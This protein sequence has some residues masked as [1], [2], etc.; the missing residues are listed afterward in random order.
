MQQVAL[1]HRASLRARRC[2][3]GSR[4]TAKTAWLRLN[5]YARSM[6]NE[7]RLLPKR[8]RQR[9]IASVVGRKRI[10]T[11]HELLAALAA[12]GCRVTQATVSRD[13]RDLGL[14]KTHDLLG[15]PRYVLPRNG[16]RADP[17]ENLAGVLTQFGRGAVAA[18]NIVV[19]RS[20]LGSAPAI[21]NALDRIEHRLVVGTLA[22]DDTCLVVTRTAADARQLARELGGR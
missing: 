13:I 19:V 7:A 2:Q 5:I 10:G 6:Q 12:T 1:R 11:Q 17:R 15:R 4:T 14:E 20:D 16:R 8:E 18:Q 3:M 22:G 9:L 21:A